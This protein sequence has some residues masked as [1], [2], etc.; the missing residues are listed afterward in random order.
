MAT[1]HTQ[2]ILIVDDDQEL[3]A[4]LSELIESFGISSRIASS[5]AEARDMFQSDRPDAALLDVHLGGESGLDLAG[6]WL[7]QPCP[8][9]RVILITGDALSV[10]DLSR[11]GGR[12]PPVLQ[13]PVDIAQLVALLN[14]PG[15]NGVS[16]A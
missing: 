5:C 14:A 3:A 10:R 6:E 9:T 13:K 12:T 16:A 11:F 15:A 1:A 4:E 8:M 7:L 2:R